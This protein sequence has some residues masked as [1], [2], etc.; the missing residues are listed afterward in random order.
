ME[1]SSQGSDVIIHHRRVV[2]VEAAEIRQGDMQVLKHSNA[3]CRGVGGVIVRLLQQ[4]PWIQICAD[5]DPAQRHK[6]SGLH[7]HAVKPHGTGNAAM[8]VQREC[9]HVPLITST[10]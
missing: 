8:S 9:Q 3:V 7:H 10:A 4:S 5:W 2:Q 1:S 6:E